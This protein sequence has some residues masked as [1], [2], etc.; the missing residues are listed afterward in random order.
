MTDKLDVD[1]LLKEWENLSPEEMK[2]LAKKYDDD[3]ALDDLAKKANTLN[4]ITCQEDADRID[5]ELEVL[6]HFSQQIK[7]NLAKGKV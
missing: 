2:R 7:A 4:P 1:Q 3:K 5:K 6:L